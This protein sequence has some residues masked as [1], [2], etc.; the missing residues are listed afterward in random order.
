MGLLVC[1]LADVGLV[2]HSVVYFTVVV[3]DLVGFYR[4]EVRYILLEMK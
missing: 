3:Q 2:E 1:V 4:K